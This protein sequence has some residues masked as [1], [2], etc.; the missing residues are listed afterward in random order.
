VRGTRW[1]YVQYATGE[2][3]LYDLDADPYELQ[4]VASK[5][6]NAGILDQ[7]RSDDHVL[8][9]PRPPRFKWTH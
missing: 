7:M 2:E 9:D 6:S 5:P 4:N 1:V 3:E 8:C